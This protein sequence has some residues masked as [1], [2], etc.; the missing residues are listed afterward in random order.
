MHLAFSHDSSCN[1]PCLRGQLAR[2]MT[3]LRAAGVPEQL[4]AHNLTVWKNQQLERVNA[5]KN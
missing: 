1:D 3:E 4:V 2:K 5:Q